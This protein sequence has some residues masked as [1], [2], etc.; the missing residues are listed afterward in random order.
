MIFTF[1]V[2]TKLHLLSAFGYTL[3]MFVKKGLTS[4]MG[5]VNLIGVRENL[6]WEKS[7]KKKK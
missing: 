1:L 2:L 6:F 7:K 4:Q 3:L 5:I